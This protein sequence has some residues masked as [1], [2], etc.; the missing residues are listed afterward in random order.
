MKVYFTITISELRNF[1]LARDNNFEWTIAL[2]TVVNCD[3]QQQL[4]VNSPFDL[5]HMLLG[6]IL[7][8]WNAFLSQVNN[9]LKFKFLLI[10][11]NMFM[12]LFSFFC[13]LHIKI[14]MNLDENLLFKK[15][16]LPTNQLQTKLWKHNYN[17]CIRLCQSP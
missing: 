16:S 9:N 6:L 2:T 17:S 13:Y 15:V 7:L 4:F 11:A 3:D 12:L 8:S 14:V 5:V 1:S 10:I